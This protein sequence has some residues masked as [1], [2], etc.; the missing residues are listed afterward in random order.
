MRERNRFLRLAGGQA[1]RGADRG[2][3]NEDFAQSQILRRN[4]PRNPRSNP[5][6]MADAMTASFTQ[7]GLAGSVQESEKPPIKGEGRW[8]GEAVME[9]SLNEDFAQKPPCGNTTGRFGGFIQE[10]AVGMHTSRRAQE[11]PFSRNSL[12]GADTVGGRLSMTFIIR[13]SLFPFFRFSAIIIADAGQKARGKSGKM[14]KGKMEEVRKYS[15]ASAAPAPPADRA[16]PDSASAPPAPRPVLQRLAAP[17]TAR[18][19]PRW[20]PELRGS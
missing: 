9:G 6:V 7:G 18:R 10:A 17:A 2:S 3:L 5:P 11:A 1:S 13:S 19:T 15:P 20:R 8:H 16:A 12:M 4:R 14:E